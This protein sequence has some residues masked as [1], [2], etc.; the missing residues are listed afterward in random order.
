MYGPYGPFVCA[1]EPFNPVVPFCA[2]YHFG[3]LVSELAVFLVNGV[4][5]IV[6]FNLVVYFSCEFAD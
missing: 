5:E 3:V 1:L 6:E 4:L 2:V